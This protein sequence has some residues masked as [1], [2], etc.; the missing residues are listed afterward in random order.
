M[1]MFDRE[2]EAKRKQNLKELEDRRLLFAQELEKRNF[3]P[4]RMLFCSSEDGRFTALARHADSY[5]V[6]TSPVFGQEGDFTIELLPKLSYEREEVYEKGT[7]LNGAFG[8]G[9][10]GARGFVISIDLGNGEQARM[11]IVA[12]RT[13]WLEAP[14]KKNPLL[15]LKRRRGNANIIWDLMPIEPGQLSKIEKLLEEHYLK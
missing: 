4:E 12:G 5:A 6:V 3:K 2:A 15:N 7:G 1:P 14:L 9:K 10:K 13:S 8:F 11:E